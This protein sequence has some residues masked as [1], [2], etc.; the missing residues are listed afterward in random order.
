MHV[1]H[2][3]K[4]AEKKHGI[5]QIKQIQQSNF[6]HQMYSGAKLFH[7]YSNKLNQS[8]LLTPYSST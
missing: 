6:K 7:W 1:K 3:T 4:I 5:Q 8:M 2:V